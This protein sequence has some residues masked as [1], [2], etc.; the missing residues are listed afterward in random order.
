MIAPFIFYAVD[1]TVTYYDFPSNWL[2]IG[3]KLPEK[4]DEHI[5]IFKVN[6]EGELEKIEQ[7]DE[8]SAE[9]IEI[10]TLTGNEL[11]LKN[12]AVDTRYLVRFTKEN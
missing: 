9:N 8:T 10:S 12:I 11:I 2:D 4:L 6:E 1:M 7:G 3:G 5:Q